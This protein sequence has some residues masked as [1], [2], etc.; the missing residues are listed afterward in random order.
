MDFFLVLVFLILTISDS[1][2]LLVLLFF[3]IILQKWSNFEG[4]VEAV[5]RKLSVTSN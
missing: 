3:E 2:S 4:M 1:P 5:D